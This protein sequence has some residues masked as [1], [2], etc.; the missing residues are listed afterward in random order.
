[1]PGIG[2]IDVKQKKSIKFQGQHPAFPVVFLDESRYVA[3]VETESGSIL[4]VWQ[5][6]P[7]G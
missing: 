2:K 3:I 5:A 6:V 1:M 7:G 4:E